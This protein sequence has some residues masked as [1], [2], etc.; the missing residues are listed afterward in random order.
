MLVL[1]ESKYRR[2]TELKLILRK[3]NYNKLIQDYDSEEFVE[4]LNAGFYK[5]ISTVYIVLLFS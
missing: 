4:C 5:N 2:K 3:Q 1:C